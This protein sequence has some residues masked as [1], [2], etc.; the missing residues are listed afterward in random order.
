MKKLLF[1]LPVLALATIFLAWCS[2][3]SEYIQCTEEQ[4]NAE[5]CTMEYMPVCGDDWETYWNVCS[6]C[7]SQNI[8]GYKAGECVEEVCD[9]EDEV[10][11]TPELE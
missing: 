8:D 7:A 11:E 6:A 10:C 9:P 3:N 4:K 1:V 5:V 2:N